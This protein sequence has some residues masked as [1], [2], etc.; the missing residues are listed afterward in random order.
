MEQILNDFWWIPAISVPLL[1]III[2]VIKKQVSDTTTPN[3]RHQF[4]LLGITIG[5]CG[6]LY[7]LVVRTSSSI[8]TVARVFF[9]FAVITCLCILASM[10][11]GPRTKKNES[12]NKAL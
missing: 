4:V 6:S 3:Q 8:F 2:W 5:I 9:A 11:V 1:A 12:P 7:P 10:V